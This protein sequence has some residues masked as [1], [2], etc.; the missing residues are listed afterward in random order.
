MSLLKLSYI[1]HGWHLE[2]HD[3]PLFRNKISA[4][5]YGP[6]IP[7]LYLAFRD[8]GIMSKMEI[9]GYSG[10]FDKERSSCLKQT[11]QIYGRMPPF[12]LSRLTHLK[13]GPWDVT[14]K[15]RG[16]YAEIP[17]SLIKTHYMKKRLEAQ[18]TSEYKE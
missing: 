8:Q 16:L 5:Q 14:L 2:M 9:P 10:E 6:V 11:Y 18:Q 4:W 15:V 12:Y 3:A 17:H 1:A 7:E 13:N